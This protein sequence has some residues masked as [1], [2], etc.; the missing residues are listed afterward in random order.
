MAT[1]GSGQGGSNRRRR[2]PKKK[3]GGAM[4]PNLA[5]KFEQFQSDAQKRRGKHETRGYQRQNIG[6]FGKDIEDKFKGQEYV[7]KQ[8]EVSSLT[9]DQISKATTYK[10][11]SKEQNKV[12]KIGDTTKFEQDAMDYK[13]QLKNEQFLK[14]KKEEQIEHLLTAEVQR[15][16]GKSEWNKSLI[17]SWMGQI[18]KATGDL[19][20]K[21]LKDGVYKYCTDVS[22]L[23]STAIA[24]Q[25]DVLKSSTDY[26][27]NLKIKNGHGLIVVINC[28]AFKIS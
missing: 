3:G 28:H 22:I 14:L 1:Q 19:L 24:R 10:Q 6:R 7:T 18:L 25:S 8:Q 21:Y 13:E 9:N 17:E 5:K 23:K 16:I 11:F 4:A 12:N 20:D 2:G 26:S 15:I 27:F